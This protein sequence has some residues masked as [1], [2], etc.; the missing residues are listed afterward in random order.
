MTLTARGCRDDYRPGRF[1]RLLMTRIVASVA[2]GICVLL[3]GMIAIAGDPSVLLIFIV[4]GVV[5]ITI[6]SA[7]AETV[8][9]LPE[10]I[11]E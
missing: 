6:G 5:Y 2:A 7:Y 9:A 3:A 11:V 4:G 1:L 8:E 10:G